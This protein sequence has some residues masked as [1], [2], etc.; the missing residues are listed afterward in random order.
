M[1]LELNGFSEIF[2]GSKILVIL[3]FG[4][5]SS[6]SSELHKINETGTLRLI[7]L[8]TKIK[9][10]NIPKRRVVCLL[11]IYEALCMVLHYLLII[12][13]STHHFIHT[14]KPSC[15]LG[16]DTQTKESVLETV[17]K[18]LAVKVELET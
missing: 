3:Y 16:C 8:I 12:I 7:N 1:G 10:L 9:K 13:L 5:Q 14:S 17:K 6:R 2:S 11:S 15:A 18:W 4:S